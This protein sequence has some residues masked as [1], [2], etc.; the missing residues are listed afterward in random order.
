MRSH[1]KDFVRAFL[2]LVPLAM[3]P[4]CGGSGSDEAPVAQ[5]SQTPVSTPVVQAPSNH[6]PIIDGDA[7]NVAQVGAEY[8]FQP[9]WSD[10][11]G[12]AL[13]F[14]ANNLPPWAELDHTTGRISGTPGVSD[15][16]TYESISITVADASHQV[17]SRDF[18]INVVGAA[19]GV[20]SLRWPAPVSKVDGSVLDDLAGYRI[21]YGR[22]PEDLDHSVYIADPDAHS[23]EFVTLDSG[24]WYFA[25]VAVNAGGEEGPATTPA[26]KV[27]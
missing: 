11:D 12:D 24:T 27:I 3:C 18:A 22:D 17:S 15:I 13:T 23:Y 26:M 2:P 4:G 20:A 21:L 5:V 6:A 25:I 9:D 1:A 16:G 19:S 8:L 10:A 14:T 7:N